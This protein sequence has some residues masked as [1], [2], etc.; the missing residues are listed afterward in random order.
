MSK[1]LK[2]LNQA[3]NSALHKTKVSGSVCRITKAQV[4]SIKHA[5]GD[6]EAMLGCGEDDSQWKRHIKNMERFL[7]NNGLD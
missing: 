3:D 7:I 1:K 2:T 6:M 4:E 5:I